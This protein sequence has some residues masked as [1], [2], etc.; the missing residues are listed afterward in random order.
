MDQNEARTR[1][2]KPT[3]PES[4]TPHE[5]YNTGVYIHVYIR[6]YSNSLSCYLCQRKLMPIYWQNFIWGNKSLRK[7]KLTLKDPPSPSTQPQWF[8]MRAGCSHCNS[9]TESGS[10]MHSVHWCS[11]KESPQ[12]L[13]H[14]VCAGQNHQ[15]TSVIDITEY[16]HIIITIVQVWAS[17]T[18][19]GAFPH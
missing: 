7:L 2:Y 9:D 16:A 3:N 11:F 6:T 10:R 12:F 8:R 5:H 17:M 18:T 4:P 15:S 19:A 14:S 1:A 13:F